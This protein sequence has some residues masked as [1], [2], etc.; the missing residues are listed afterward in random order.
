MP[1][2]LVAE[3]LAAAGRHHDQAVA[4]VERRLHRLA[5]P[6]PELLVAEVREQ[7][8]GIGGH[9]LSLCAGVDARG[10]WGD[11][12][13]TGTAS[14]RDR[15]GAAL[16][17]PAGAVERVGPLL[18]GEGK[19]AGEA[20]GEVFLLAEDLAAAVETSN[21]VTFEVPALTTS[22]VTGPAA[23]FASAGSHPA[24]VSLKDIVLA[25]FGAASWSRSRRPRT[26]E[27]PIPAAISAVGRRHDSSEEAPCS[28]DWKLRPGSRQGRRS[29]EPDG[30]GGEAA[31]AKGRRAPSAPR[32]AGRRAP[33]RRLAR[34][35]GR[36]SRSAASPRRSLGWTSQERSTPAPGG[37]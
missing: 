25:P 14:A 35:A 27:R 10:G 30:D 8:V 26:A 17:R 1:G 11:E 6:G 34:A 15:E 31:E 37:R 9:Q 5:L 13:A 32:R 29:P 22:K 16:A 3:A 19:A 20:V 36:A 23:T 18:Q 7:R 28:V 12:T 24:S 21:S 33:R 2:Q 4:A